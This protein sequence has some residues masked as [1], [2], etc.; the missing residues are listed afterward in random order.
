MVNI[1]VDAPPNSRI[2]F[3]PVK[4]NFG[5]YRATVSGAATFVQEAPAS[6]EIQQSSTWALSPKMY[7]SLLVVPPDS[8]IFRGDPG[9]AAKLASMRAPNGASSHVRL[10]C[11]PPDCETQTSAICLLGPRPPTT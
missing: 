3:S 1:A 2:E 8:K 6:S 7:R 9:H 10:K 4:C 5:E 11:C